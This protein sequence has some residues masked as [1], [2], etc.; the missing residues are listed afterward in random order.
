MI[1]LC[2]AD[3]PATDF[4]LRTESLGNDLAHFQSLDGEPLVAV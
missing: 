4:P 1:D 2:D 3:R